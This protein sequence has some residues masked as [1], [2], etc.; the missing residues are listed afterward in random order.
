MLTVVS[1]EGGGRKGLKRRVD[2]RAV[3]W[4]VVVVGGREGVRNLGAR[5]LPTVD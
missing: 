3:G 4:G 1:V 2:N 5:S